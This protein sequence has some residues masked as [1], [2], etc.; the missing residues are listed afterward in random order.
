MNLSTIAASM[1]KK[2][3]QTGSDY[4][5]LPRGLHLALSIEGPS[6]TL[7]LSRKRVPPS[8]SEANICRAVFQVPNGATM[9]TRDNRI[10]IRWTT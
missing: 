8:Q 1:T 3:I 4:Y 5:Q 10:T 9:T 2:A 6:R 7:T